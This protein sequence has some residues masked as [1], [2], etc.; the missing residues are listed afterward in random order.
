MIA[1]LYDKKI[2]LDISSIKNLIICLFIV[3]FGQLFLLLLSRLIV[4]LTIGIAE[5][6]DRKVAF[7]FFGC[8]L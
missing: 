4:G 6:I 8:Y 3:T 7:D 5:L 1:G 2:N